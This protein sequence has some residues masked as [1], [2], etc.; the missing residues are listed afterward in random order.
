L[1]FFFGRGCEVSFGSK[2]AVEAMRTDVRFTL[3]SRRDEGF[4]AVPPWAK[5]R[6]AGTHHPVLVQ[7]APRGWLS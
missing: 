5:S 4:I 1:P 2:A 3:N 7:Q 6:L